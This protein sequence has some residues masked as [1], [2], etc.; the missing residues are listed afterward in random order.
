VTSNLKGSFAMSADGYDNISSNTGLFGFT[1]DSAMSQMLARNWWVLALR[2]VLALIFGII[3]LLLPG[4]TIAALVMLFAVYML[5][6]G[7]FAIIVGARA[8]QR[9]ERW[10]LLILEGVVDLIAAAVAIIWPLA[11]I[12]AF[13]ILMAAWA[14]V[15][16]ALMFAAAFRLHLEHGRWLLG[17]SGAASVIW[18]FLLLMWP[19]VGAVVLTWWMGA[20]ALVFGISLLILAFRLRR[21]RDRLTPAGMVHA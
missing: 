7:V 5:V 16:G 8:A 10:G 4:V 11:T 20:Y 9:H 13:V 21:Q 2:G 3:A 6:D 14:I 1:A 17:F 12:V 19:L 15:S 18:G